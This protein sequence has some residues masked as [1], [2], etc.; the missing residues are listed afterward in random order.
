MNPED[1]AL[2]NLD[3][4]KYIAF[5][6][7]IT[8]NPSSGAGSVKRIKG[9]SLEETKRE[10]FNAIKGSLYDC[11]LNT[12]A[13]PPNEKEIDNINKSVAKIKYSQY[14]TQMS[15]MFSQENYN[16]SYDSCYLSKPYTARTFQINTVFVNCKREGDEYSCVLLPYYA[17][18]NTTSILWSSYLFYHP[19]VERKFDTARRCSLSYIDEVRSLLKQGNHFVDTPYRPL[20]TS[21]QVE[22]IY[23]KLSEKIIRG[24]WLFA[25]LSP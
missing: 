1:Y 23:K 4:N 21:E 22:E 6:Q 10:L 18:L 11:H 8:M 14:R 13:S 2:L 9:M 20:F 25:K 16:S 19:N 3:Q 12:C 7:K 17:S 15:I 24:R 5:A